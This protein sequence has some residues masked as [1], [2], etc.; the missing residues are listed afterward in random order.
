MSGVFAVAL[1]LAA[2]EAEEE[3]DLDYLLVVHHANYH[4]LGIYFHPAVLVVVVV[5]FFSFFL[6]GLCFLALQA[7]IVKIDTKYYGISVS[8]FSSIPID[9]NNLESKYLL[10]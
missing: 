9:K 1:N 7:H 2:G 6:S 5:S 10:F 8:L 4:T 3:L